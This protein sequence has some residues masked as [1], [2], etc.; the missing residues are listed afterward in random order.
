[1]LSKIRH[2][3]MTIGCST[4]EVALR[5]MCLY[6]G[7]IPTRLN[8]STPRSMLE[9]VLQRGRND[10]FFKKGERIVL[11]SDPSNGTENRRLF[12]VHEI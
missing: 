10:G 1:M 6:W 9:E 2:A 7:V 3:A 4:N 8:A 11:L 5:R 12:Y